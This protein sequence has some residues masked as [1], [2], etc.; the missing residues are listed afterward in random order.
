[1]PNVSGRMRL[2]FTAYSG[3]R[4]MLGITAFSANLPTAPTYQRRQPTNGANLPTTPTYQ[5]RQPAGKSFAAC[6]AVFVGWRRGRRPM[7]NVSGRMRLCFT[8]YSGGR[9][10]L[11]IT[12][13]S[14]NLPTAPTYQRCQPTNGTNLPTAPTCQRHQPANGTNLPTAPTCGQISRCLPQA[15]LLRSRLF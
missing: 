12:A 14:A 15:A 10:M 9:L 6:G 8:A 7:P 1:M 4:L 13:F 2:C 5:R 11:G 3:G